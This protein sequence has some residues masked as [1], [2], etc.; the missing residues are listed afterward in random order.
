MI[1]EFFKPTWLRMTLFPILLLFSPAIFKVC[2][3]ACT[4]NLQWLAGI[5]LLASKESGDLTFISMLIWFAVSYF[6]A[7]LAAVNYEYFAER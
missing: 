5:K 3:G 4:L 6:L 7:C 2:N 1:K